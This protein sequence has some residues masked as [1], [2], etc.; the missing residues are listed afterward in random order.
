MPKVTQYV[1]EPGFR[2][3][4]LIPEPNLFYHG[5]FLHYISPQLLTELLE[6]MALGQLAKWAS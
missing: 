2:I 3:S 1:V 5:V 6:I 4:N